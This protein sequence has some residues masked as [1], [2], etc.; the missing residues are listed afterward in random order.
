M[1]IVVQQDASIPSISKQQISEPFLDR[2]PYTTIVVDVSPLVIIG[3]LGAY[4]PL[5]LRRSLS[6]SSSDLQWLNS[7]NSRVVS[8][9]TEHSNVEFNSAGRCTTSVKHSESPI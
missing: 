4:K 5:S 6:K 7:H 8:K 3:S 2:L 1:M 9:E